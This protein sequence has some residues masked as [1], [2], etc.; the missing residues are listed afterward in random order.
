MFFLDL[1]IC[2]Q[3][4]SY[5]TLKIKIIFLKTLK[6]FFKLKASNFSPKLVFLQPCFYSTVSKMPLRCPGVGAYRGECADTEPS[7]SDAHQL[8]AQFLHHFYHSTATKVTM[9]R[10]CHLFSE[11]DVSKAY[12]DRYLIFLLQ[13]DTLS[14][15]A[16]RTGG[17]GLVTR[18]R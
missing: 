6:K 9:L 1:N 13:C 2:I 14:P 11:N 4:Y 18:S 17:L 3:S 16:Y 7:R 15:C 10:Y 5:I 8:F 12:N